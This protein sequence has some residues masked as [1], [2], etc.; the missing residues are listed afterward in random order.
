M[1]TTEI[2]VGDR[3]RFKAV[4]RWNT[5]TEWRLVVAI[6]PIRVRF[7]GWSHFQL[8]DHEI[9]ETERRAKG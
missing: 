5:R 9:S 2:K 1:D 6:D 4:C 7:A 8:R 3:V